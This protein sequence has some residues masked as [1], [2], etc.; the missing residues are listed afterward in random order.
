MPIGTINQLNSGRE[1]SNDHSINVGSPDSEAT[2]GNS[3]PIQPTPEARQFFYPPRLSPELEGYESHA[4]LLRDILLSPRRNLKSKGKR[5]RFIKEQC[6]RL[7]KKI[8][9][10]K[11]KRILKKTK[12]THKKDLVF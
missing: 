4:D 11:K 3:Q 1:E 5:K 7:Q 9:K 2:I 12:F 10:N 6:I 8:K